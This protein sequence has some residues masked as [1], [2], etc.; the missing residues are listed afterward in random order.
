MAKRERQYG[1]LC[2]VFKLLGPEGI[3]EL[4]KGKTVLQSTVRRGVRWPRLGTG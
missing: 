4:S 3:G 2:V 1:G